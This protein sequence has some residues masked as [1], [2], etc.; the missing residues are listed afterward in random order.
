MCHI[1]QSPWA[2]FFYCQGAGGNA[3]VNGPAAG[4]AAAAAQH[5]AD[6]LPDGMA[7]ANPN[8]AGNQGDEAELD[9]D[10][11]DDDGE[12]DEEEDDE[13]EEGREEDAA[14][15]NNGGQGQWALL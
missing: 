15:A 2:H 3:A 12:E 5:P 14:D 9:E 10:E 6:P 13:D 8:E 7:P 11:E 1:F 4:D